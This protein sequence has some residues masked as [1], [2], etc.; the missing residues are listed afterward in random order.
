[1]GLVDDIIK[2]G[3]ENLWNPEKAIQYICD[4]SLSKKRIELNEKQKNILQNLKTK[5]GTVKF[6]IDFTEDQIQKSDFHSEEEIQGY[7]DSIFSTNELFEEYQDKIIESIPNVVMSS[8]KEFVKSIKQTLYST[9]DEMIRNNEEILINV[10]KDIQKKYFS[11]LRVLKMVIQILTEDFETSN[12]E[13]N[14]D[15]PKMESIIRI[16]GESILVSN[17][18]VVL[19]ENGYSDGALSRWRNLYEQATIALFISQ[20]DNSISERFLQHLHIDNFKSMELYNEHSKD[21]QVEP[22]SE[23]EISEITNL[24][25]KYIEEYNIVDIGDYGWASTEFNLPKNKQVRFYHIENESGIR[26]LKPYY[27][28]ACSRVHH[29][30]KGMLFKM[31]LKKEHQGTILYG[32][33][34]Q[35]HYDPIQLTILCLLEISISKLNCIES[36]DNIFNVKLIESLYDD[37]RELIGQAE[38]Y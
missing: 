14:K 34:N 16:M 15:D 29:N 35:G 31:G 2:Q 38:K 9:A 36:Y 33:S 28:L 25:K 5:N 24:K 6:S 17:E 3:F 13:S 4:T 19:L 30:S 22:Y 20:K 26:F 32:P 10:K 8:I 27:K 7:L 1:M 18:I 11:E 12:G 21:L 23:Q 37:I